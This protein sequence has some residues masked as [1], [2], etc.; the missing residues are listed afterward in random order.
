MKKNYNINPN[1]LDATKWYLNKLK[2]ELSLI[3]PRAEKLAKEDLFLS[4]AF[5]TRQTTDIIDL[6]IKNVQSLID[7]EK[8]KFKKIIYF[9]KDLNNDTPSTI[10]HVITRKHLKHKIY[11]LYKSN[12]L[13]DKEIV[14]AFL[15]P[16]ALINKIHTVTLNKKIEIDDNYPFKRYKK[17]TCDIVTFE[18][19]LIN[20]DTWTMQDHWSLLR[21]ED[22]FK[23]ILKEFGI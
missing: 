6:C 4:D 8:N 7:W 10:E 17:I 3:K 23:S 21:K 1:P 16:V 22:E 9:Q 11:N 18:N 12:N 20:K 2:E 15:S 14:K 13:T 19:T 5:I